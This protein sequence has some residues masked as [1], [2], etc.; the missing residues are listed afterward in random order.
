MTETGRPTVLGRTLGTELRWLRNAA[1]LTIQQVAKA[2]DCS[3][4]KISRMETAQVGASPRDVSAPA[5]LYG[6][7]QEQRDRLVQLARDARAASATA[8]GT[9]MAT[10]PRPGPGTAAWRP[11]RTGSTPTRACWFLGCCRLPTMP[12]RSSG[13]CSL[14]TDL[15]LERDRVVRRFARAFQRLGR[16]ALDPSASPTRIAELRDRL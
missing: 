15:F 12:G 16:L 5:E 7:D 8:G 1:E 11:R 10:C 4:S 9:T 2:L 6:C 3:P 14:A 13:R